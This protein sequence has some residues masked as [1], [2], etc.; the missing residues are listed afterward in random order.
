MSLF[1]NDYIK[2]M[3]KQLAAFIAS[4]LKASA[5]KNPGEAAMLVREAS[6]QV[7]GIEWDVL[8]STDVPSAIMLLRGDPEKIRMYADLLEA[9]AQVLE[10]HGD[11]ARAQLRRDRAVALLTRAERG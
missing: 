4:I 3:L 6:S 8:S 1:E 7:L 5:A 9:E 11:P 10:Q 2:R